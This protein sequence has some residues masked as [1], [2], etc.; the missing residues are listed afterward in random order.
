MSNVKNIH[1]HVDMHAW[2]MD[3]S[4]RNFEKFKTACIVIYCAIPGLLIIDIYATWG[5]QWYI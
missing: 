3:L 2:T 5:C 4:L 1:E